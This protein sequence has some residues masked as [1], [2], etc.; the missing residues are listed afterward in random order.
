MDTDKL[1][2]LKYLINK[3]KST[4]EICEALGFQ[5]AELY[6]YVKYLKGVGC[7]YDIVNGIAVKTDPEVYQHQIYL[8]N[9]RLIKACFV[10][11]P[12]YGSEYDR[13][14]IMRF[15]YNECERRGIDKIICAGDLSDGFYPDRETY[16]KHQKVVGFDKM[17]EYILNV[18]PYSRYIKFYTIG[19]NHDFTFKKYENK[20]II[21]EVAY[22]RDDIIYLGQDVADL[23]LG[24]L[25]LRVYHGYGSGKKTMLERAQK[26]Y[27]SIE[28]NKPDIIQM[29][30]FHHSLFTVFNDTYLLQN[31][32]LIDQTPYAE[33][34]KFGTERSCFFV[35]IEID[36][37]GNIIRFIPEVVPFEAQKI[38]TRRP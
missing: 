5:L 6:E 15:I 18:H 24:D 35:T 10:S 3:K 36:E 37:F 30:H 16:S 29:G 8:G 4:D 13:P 17:L 38:R 20:D 23:S 25:S 27:N 14:D 21:E 32:A 12:H 34:S 11:D 2:K 31:A 9:T 22:R 19:G 28:G 26:Y 7:D 33:H 1:N